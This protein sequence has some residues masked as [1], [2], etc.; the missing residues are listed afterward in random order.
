MQPAGFPR[1][2][3][4]FSRIQNAIEWFA[5]SRILHF[6]A[7]SLRNGV[8]AC[9]KCCWRTHCVE[10]GASLRAVGPDPVHL[11]LIQVHRP[12]TDPSRARQPG[13]PRD[14]EG[15]SAGTCRQKT[16][17]RPWVTRAIR[18]P[19]P[20]GCEPPHPVRPCG[21]EPCSTE[22]FIAGGG[23]P[24]HALTERMNSA[25]V[26]QLNVVT[27]YFRV[28]TA[29]EAADRAAERARSAVRDRGGIRRR[30]GRQRTRAR[31]RGKVWG[32]A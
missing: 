5:F 14:P 4:S 27:G 20:R 1:G 22:G 32:R 8:F 19:R 3:R 10:A 13:A 6:K 23:M 29:G 25:I 16:S 17:S 9:V 26:L 15:G 30:G 31:G 7:L 2:Y 18:A 21:H 28:R 24:E 12:R 11:D